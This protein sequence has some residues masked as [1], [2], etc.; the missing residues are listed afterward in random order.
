MKAKKIWIASKG[1]TIFAT[2]SDKSGDFECIDGTSYCEGDYVDYKEYVL[3]EVEQ[4]D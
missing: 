3:I 1:D 2:F 4:D